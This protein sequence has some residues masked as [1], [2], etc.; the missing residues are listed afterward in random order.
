M[1]RNEWR[2]RPIY[3]NIFKR[4]NLLISSVQDVFH[5]V[6]NSVG[7]VKINNWNCCA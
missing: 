2:Y 4:D 6:N 3:T 7:S 1:L 5:N